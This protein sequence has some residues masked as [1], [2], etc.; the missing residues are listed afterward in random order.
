MLNS[1]A[2]LSRSKA[3]L[4]AENALLRQQLA[5]LKR[6]T[7]RS[8]L[9]TADRYSLQFFTRIVKTWRQAL[10]IVQPAALLR[11]YRKSL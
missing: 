2:D 4:V 10:L 7:K 9:T 1:V 3:A 6:Q 5:I 11:W 8:S